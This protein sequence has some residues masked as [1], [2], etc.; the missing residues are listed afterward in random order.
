[1]VLG[2]GLM[3]ATACKDDRD[4]NPTL[5]MPTTFHLNDPVFKNVLTSLEQTADDSPL[6]FTWSQ[7]EVGFP[8][9]M[10]YLLEFST[11]G[12]FA[13]AQ[14][15]TPEG[16]V[17]DL[18]TTGTA[19]SIP[20]AT[21][22]AKALNSYLQILGEWASVEDAPQ[23]MTLYARVKAF[24]PHASVTETSDTIISN[25]VSFKVAPYFANTKEA[26][27][28]IWYIV[29]DYA[30]SDFNWKNGGTENIGAGLL[31]LQAS[32]SESYDKISGKG[33]ISYTGYF[34]ASR[35]FKLVRVPGEWGDQWGSTDGGTTGLKNDGG[36]QNLFVPAD[37]YYTI[38]LNTATD[39]LTITAADIAPTVYPQMLISG[40]FN[41]WSTDV[42]MTPATT[43]D[44]SKCHDWY[45]DIDATGGM[46]TAKFLTDNTWAVN[47]GDT[48]FP[49]GKGSQNGPNIP[50][51]EGKW[52]VFF[53]D[54][55]GIYY[56]HAIQ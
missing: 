22:S 1:M 29:G 44:E 16:A 35:G 33:I 19:Y 37:G 7:P 18:F 55:S 31:P 2:L 41:G 15:K 56:F 20:E 13:Y 12:K 32:T 54:I 3:V 11:N 9:L 49:Y 42:Q 26:E 47:W 50:V 10:N 34:V 52:R 30:N 21:L 25:V 45:Y 40:D 43:F 5:V 24:V 27:P 46:T 17:A 36:S 48:E 8:V 6:K 38:K 53:N 28:E 23:E 51:S 39:E 4:S 14:G